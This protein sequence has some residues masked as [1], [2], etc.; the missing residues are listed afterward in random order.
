M[1][2]VFPTGLTGLATDAAAQKRRVS[3]WPE[4]RRTLARALKTSINWFFNGFG[5][6]GG[7]RDFNMA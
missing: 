4:I 5:G 3:T 6:V 1:A 7:R 2:T